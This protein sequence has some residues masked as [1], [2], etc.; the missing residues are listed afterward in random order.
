MSDMNR[1]YDGI[2][3]ELLRAL[4]G[5]RS[6]RGFS[7]LF[8]FATNVAYRWEAG[9]RFPTVPQLFKVLERIGVPVQQALE[10]VDS[11]TQR[12]RGTAVDGEHYAGAF[13][14]LHQGTRSISELARST[15][16]H[17]LQISRV[18]S[19]RTQA[20]LPM[21]LRLLDAL[22]GRVDEYIGAWVNLERAPHL[23][24]RLAVLGAWR[25]LAYEHPI[26]EAITATLESAAYKAQPS[27]DDSWLGARLGI[28][29]AQ[30]QQAL[31]AM[32]RAGVVRL[33]NGRWV[34]LEGRSVDTRGEAE[35]FSAVKKYWAQIAAER[36]EQDDAKAA[37]LVFCCS[38]QATDAVERLYRQTWTQARAIL[39]D[40]AGNERV[41][42]INVNWVP[43]DGQRALLDAE[44]DHSDAPQLWHRPP[45]IQGL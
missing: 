23:Q 7:A 33:E 40:D 19:G 28:A 34:P 39:R 45:P 11:S 4:R 8:G 44:H 26:T 27:P 16:L 3:S 38:S 24:E 32:S 14:S 5:R 17:R 31:Q 15:G 6:Q 35:R 41:V 12:L 22:T 43:L 9:Q 21:F 10:G 36:V 1:D 18:L 30:V 13:L 29:P 37:Y 2:A 42:L 20:R 25:E